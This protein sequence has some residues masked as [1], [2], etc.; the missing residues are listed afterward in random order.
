VPEGQVD[1]KKKKK[2]KKKKI[3]CGVG[4]PPSRLL[5]L[6][7]ANENSQIGFARLF[8]YLQI[9]MRKK[10]TKLKES[11]EIIETPSQITN[12]KSHSTVS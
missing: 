3:L 2:K 8:P 6:S 10:Q 9:Q 1:T 12:H 4:L 7:D 5:I 11:N